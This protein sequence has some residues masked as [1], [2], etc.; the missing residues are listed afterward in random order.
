MFTLKENVK[1]RF[2]EESGKVS[3]QPVFHVNV[4]LIVWVDPTYI[5][6]T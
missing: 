4:T 5:W 3:R 2:L 6:D 1:N